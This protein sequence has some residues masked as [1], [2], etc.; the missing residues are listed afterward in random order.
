MILPVSSMQKN[1]LE[2]YRTFDNEKVLSSL[3]E[4][5]NIWFRLIMSDCPPQFI[6]ENQ[7]TV[8]FW[9]QNRDDLEL[10]AKERGLIP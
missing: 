7:Q 2:Y 10:V 5:E 3:K 6:A 8:V 9:Q 4:A 1:N